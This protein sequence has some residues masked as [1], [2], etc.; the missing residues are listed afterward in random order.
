M[1]DLFVEITEEG[2]K[3]ELVLNVNKM[4]IMQIG[5]PLDTKEIVEYS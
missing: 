2:R 3:L 5:K 4:K 1:C